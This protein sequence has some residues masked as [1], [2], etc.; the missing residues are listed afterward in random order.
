MENNHEKVYKMNFALFFHLFFEDARKA[1]YTVPTII[2]SIFDDESIPTTTASSYKTGGAPLPD[3]LVAICNS[4]TNEDLSNRFESILT[5]KKKNDRRPFNEQVCRRILDNCTANICS[6]IKLAKS[7]RFTFKNSLILSS[8][9]DD[10]LSIYNKIANLFIESLPMTAAEKSLTETRIDETVLELISG[11]YIHSKSLHFPTCYCNLYNIYYFSEHYEN[12][13]HC[14]LLRIY[15]DEEGQSL[16]RYI[17]GL[18]SEDKLTNEHLLNA[19]NASTNTESR[20]HFENYL[21]TITL[22]Y[23]KRVFLMNGFVDSTDFNYYLK[24]NLTGVGNRSN[25]AQ[26]LYLNLSRVSKISTQRVAYHG[27]LGFIIAAPHKTSPKIRVH[28]IGVAD[29]NI[30]ISLDNPILRNILTLNPTSKHRL[31]VQMDDDREF[32]NFLLK[33]E[34]EAHRKKT[35]AKSNID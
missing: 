25:D 35:T 8:L 13:V 5:G 11:K 4:N 27:G 23:E 21:K 10:S 32:W 19:I 1:G 31:Q 14:G 17:Y 26:T 15:V 3:V 22:G 24:I 28:R 16:A 12:E 34:A 9:E 18:T 29:V 33:C 6:L 7:N 20:N 30:P 2:N